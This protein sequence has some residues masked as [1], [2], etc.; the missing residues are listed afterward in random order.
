VVVRFPGCTDLITLT[1]S[2]SLPGSTGQSSF[3]GWRLL[4]RP[5]EPGDDSEACVSLN[6]QRSEPL[7]VSLD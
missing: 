5:V 4:D 3:H 1:P 7:A 2:G 6:E